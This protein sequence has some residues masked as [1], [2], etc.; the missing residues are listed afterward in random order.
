MKLGPLYE[1]EEPFIQELWIKAH[2]LYSDAC[3]SEGRSVIPIYR[4]EGFETAIKEFGDVVKKNHL[5]RLLHDFKARLQWFDYVDAADLQDSGE[6]S[7]SLVSDI[8]ESVEDA[9]LQDSG[10]T[11]IS[12]KHVSKEFSDKPYPQDSKRALRACLLQIKI[13][14]IFI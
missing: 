10:E 5:L 1:Y 4:E 14:V 7:R 6:S 11:S 8:D 13:K 12:D 2:K 9:D 3:I